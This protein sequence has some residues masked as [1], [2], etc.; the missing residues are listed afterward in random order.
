MY[1][2]HNQRC[3]I[4]A[5]VRTRGMLWIEDLAKIMEGAAQRP[6]VRRAQT[7]R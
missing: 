2:A 6:G 4:T 5:R 3:E 7:P 1:G